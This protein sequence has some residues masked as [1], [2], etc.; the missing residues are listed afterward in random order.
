MP[1]QGHEP[2]GNGRNRQMLPFMTAIFSSE[3]S[4]KPHSCVQLRPPS[5]DLK[6]LKPHEFICKRSTT[7]PE[8]FIIDP[9]QMP[10]L[11]M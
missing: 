3:L 9:I 10:G 6:G 11:N 4:Q 1:A 5:Q 8:K 2:R 7:E